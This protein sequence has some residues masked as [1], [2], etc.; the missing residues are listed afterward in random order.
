MRSVRLLDK[1]ALIGSGTF[2][3][4]QVTVVSAETLYNSD[5][6]S[7]SAGYVAGLTLTGQPAT[8][9][10]GS[11]WLESQSGLNNPPYPYAEVVTGGPTGQLAAV[12]SDN[13][14]SSDY[15]YW[16]PGTYV[17]TPFTPSATNKTNIII[18]SWTEAWLSGATGD[19]FFG[20]SVY[21]GSTLVA[22]GGVDATTGLAVDDGSSGPSELGSDFFQGAAGIY[23][24]LSLVLNYS[25]QS[26]GF[27]ING[28][29]I[30]TQG[31]A[32]AATQFTDADLTTYLLENG[33]GTGYGYFDGYV[34]S[35]VPEP[36]GLALGAIALL[37][38]GARKPRTTA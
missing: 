12:A 24:N 17:A 8:G 32:G 9:P 28:N 7:N 26:F 3:L 27:Y 36:G 20:I 5:D 13:I 10:A 31:F 18:V 34:V 16:Y 21:N 30:D 6:F 1:I 29:P 22:L 2:F 11:Q 35:A 23:Y 19:P 38:L 37:L 25:T 33:T 14:S 15:G 4:A